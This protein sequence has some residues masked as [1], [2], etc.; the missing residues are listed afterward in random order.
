MTVRFEVFKDFDLNK[1]TMQ[2]DIPRERVV[3]ISCVQS[4]P[5]AFGNMRVIS[6]SS[7]FADADD[8]AKHPKA[9]QEFLKTLSKA[10]PAKKEEG[11]KK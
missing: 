2:R 3:M 8:F 6:E 5:D 10:E 4:A 1:A 7:K 11:K 9:Y